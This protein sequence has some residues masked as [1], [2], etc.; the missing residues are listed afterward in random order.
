MKNKTGVVLYLLLSLGYYIDK[1]EDIDDVKIAAASISTFI[2]DADISAEDLTAFIHI[3]EKSKNDIAE[4][5]HKILSNFSER[6]KKAFGDF[7]FMTA[8]EIK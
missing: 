2:E 6:Y 5:I 8:N 7:Y 1:T 4:K 3:I